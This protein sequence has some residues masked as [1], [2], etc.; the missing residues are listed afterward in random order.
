[1]TARRFSPISPVTRSGF[2]TSDHTRGQGAGRFES[3]A[4]TPV[5]EHFERPAT[6]PSGVR[7]G[8]ET[9]SKVIWKI[10]DI[11]GIADPACRP[12]PIEIDEK[13]DV[14]LRLFLRNGKEIGNSVVFAESNRPASACITPNQPLPE[15]QKTCVE[16]IDAFS[17]RLK[18][19]V[20]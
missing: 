18:R 20:E 12:F 14:V 3:A 9:T 1:L 11:R 13:S 15:I 19:P 10:V 8:Y 7:R 4:Y 6:P 16:E 5:C 2:T 17:Q